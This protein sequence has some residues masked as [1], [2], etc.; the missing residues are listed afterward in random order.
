MQFEIATFEFSVQISTVFRCFAPDG[1][2][3]T[4]KKKKIGRQSY[5][6]RRL[7]D[8]YEKRTLL[9]FATR[10]RA[11]SVR[12]PLWQFFR[13]ARTRAR[14]G[15][16]KTIFSRVR[17]ANIMPLC[18]FDKVTDL[19]KSKQLDVTPRTLPR[20]NLKYGR[21]WIRGRIYYIGGNIHKCVCRAAAT[22]GAN[23]IPCL[24]CVPMTQIIL[25]PAR[26]S[27]S[28]P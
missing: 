25:L 1:Y 18:A 16:I 14:R 27:P 10:K 23:S 13:V 9:T 28:I 19:C 12:N 20:G 21:Q 15:G 17:P 6:K 2:I 4:I 24:Y 22:T 11:R 26:P 7:N 3:K 8:S 5:S